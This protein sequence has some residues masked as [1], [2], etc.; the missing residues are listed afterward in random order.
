MPRV[1]H[2]WLCQL[3][4]PRAHPDSPLL[5]SFATRVTGIGPPLALEDNL[6][7]LALRCPGIWS[8][9]QGTAIDSTKKSSSCLPG[10]STQPCNRQQSE[11]TKLHLQYTSQFLYLHHN[12]S[13]RRSKQST[14]SKQP[15]FQPGPAC[16]SMSWDLNNEHS[17]LDAP[18]GLFLNF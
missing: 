4:C 17:A 11:L 15:R 5:L 13:G 7:S 6:R 1:V 3:P 8:I 12:P 18:G 16:F 10:W 2:R 14:I 9:L